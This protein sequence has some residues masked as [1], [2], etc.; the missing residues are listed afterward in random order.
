M[1]WR[2]A[3]FF[4]PLLFP[5]KKRVFR[6]TAHQVVLTFQWVAREKLLNVNTA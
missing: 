4:S 3:V 2:E 5:G 1:G 6:R